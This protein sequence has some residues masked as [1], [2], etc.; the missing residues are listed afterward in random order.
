MCFET[1]NGNIVAV[2]W[3]EDGSAMWKKKIIYDNKFSECT[4]AAVYTTDQACEV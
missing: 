2:V 1:N 3:V 4:A